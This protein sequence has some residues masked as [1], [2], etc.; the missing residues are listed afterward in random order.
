MSENAELWSRPD[1]KSICITLECYLKSHSIP[2]DDY[3]SI[4]ELRQLYIK[5][6]T[7]GF[8]NERF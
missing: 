4:E 5:N 1:E 8:L 7:G 3:M 6:E 2:F